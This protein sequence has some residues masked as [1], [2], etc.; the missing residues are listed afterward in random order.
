M[1]LPNINYLRELEEQRNRSQEELKRKQKTEAQKKAQEK[2]ANLPAE[3]ESYKQEI[4]SGLQARGLPLSVREPPEDGF[5]E[6][7][8]W[9]FV[10]GYKYNHY[11][12]YGWRYQVVDPK[13]P[14]TH[15]V[16]K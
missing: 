2:K 9:L 10:S 14:E 16:S 7:A 12:R 6:I 11:Y 4:I 5:E 15:G 13:R 3:I 1:S 8:K